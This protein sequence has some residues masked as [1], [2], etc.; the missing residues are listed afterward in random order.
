MPPRPISSDLHKTVHLSKKGGGFSQFPLTVARNVFRIMKD[1]HRGDR[2]TFR[3][4][5]MAHFVPAHTTHHNIGGMNSD[6][7]RLDRGSSR[8]RCGGGGLFPPRH[9]LPQA[10]SG[11]E[12]S[13]AEEEATRIINEAIKSSES[14]KRE[15]LLEAKEEILKT[16]A[17]TRERSKSAAPSSR[18]R[19]AVYSRKRKISITRPR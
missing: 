6:R 16:A 14:K 5:S 9:S 19:S 7:N 17:N 4:F 3:L 10:R 13:S 1:Y 8:V 18:S 12:I 2:G 15:A 11:K